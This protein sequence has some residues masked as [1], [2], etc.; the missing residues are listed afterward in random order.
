M[1]CSD[2][3]Q[4]IVGYHSGD[5]SGDDKVLVETHLKECGECSL[6]LSQSA[7]VWNLLDEWKEIEPGSE[8]V[9]DFWQRV[10][11]EEAG[12]GGFLGIF[13]KFR[14]NWAIAG[15]FA[16]ILIVGIFTFA[17]FSLDSG[18]RLFTASDERDE[19]ILLELDRA[20]SSETAE[21]LAIYGPWDAGI[22]TVNINGN[23]GMN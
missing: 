9:A 19:L 13:K 22:D 16:S 1:D 10:S 3:K 6:Y 4:L 8:Y 2:F 17:I 23:G 18:N 5:L 12:R 14:F 11:R 7:E 21:V 15:A 20:T